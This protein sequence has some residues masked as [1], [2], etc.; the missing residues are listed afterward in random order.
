MIRQDAS[1]AWA[2]AERIPLMDYEASCRGAKD[3]EKVAEWILN[4]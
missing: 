4:G 1:L 2:S 3:L